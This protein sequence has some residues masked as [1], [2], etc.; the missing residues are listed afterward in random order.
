MADGILLVHAFPVD[1]RMWEPQVER[2]GAAYTVVAPDLPGFGGS[3]GAGEVMSMGAAAERCL[4]SLEVAGVGVAV[5]CGLSMGGYV[6]LEL[7]RRVPGRIAG[8]V[9]ANTTAAADTEERAAGRRALA[10]R[11]RAE[12]TGFLVEDPPPL[13]SQGAPAELRAKVRQM[14]AEQ[15]A[16]AIAAAAL[17]MSERPDSTGDLASIDV[18]TLLVTSSE[19]TLIPP[20]VT[21]SMVE[22]IRDASLEVIEGVGHL[23]N[24]EAPDRFGDLLQRFCD[25]AGIGPED[26]L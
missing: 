2:F 23:S 22:L 26:E 9:L 19:D 17:G 5:V 11:L 10:E 18:P 15:P 20:N 24:L 16:E 4:G 14:I 25:R 6:A 21:G 1:A 13:L 7:W 3:P 8:F 12:G